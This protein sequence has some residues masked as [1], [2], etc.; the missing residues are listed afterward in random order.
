MDSR[1]TPG[2]VKLVRTN[3]IAAIATFNA[4]CRV[5]AEQE[6][7][8]QAKLLD[9]ADPALHCTLQ[10]AFGPLFTLGQ[11]SV[12]LNSRHYGGKKNLMSLV[13]RLGIAWKDIV[14]VETMTGCALR[15]IVVHLTAV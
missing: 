14:A 9:S 11:A 3:H 13:T 8:V 5:N 7:I 12:V 10:T 6:R 2:C 4:A 15:R 1:L